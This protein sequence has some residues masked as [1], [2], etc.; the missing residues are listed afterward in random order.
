M[1]SV[2]TASD[3][4]EHASHASEYDNLE[5]LPLVLPAPRHGRT[6]RF[7]FLH[8][9]FTL[10]LRRH[11]ASERTSQISYEPEPPLDVLA[12]KYPNLYMTS[13]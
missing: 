13:L 10:R 1:S 5:A 7:A 12:R 3:P 6:H 4:L 9:L 2:I 8:A 11:R